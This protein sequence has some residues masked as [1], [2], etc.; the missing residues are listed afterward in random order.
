M[1]K[2][3]A[4]TAPEL[5]RLR[6]PLSPAATPPLLPGVALPVMHMTQQPNTACTYSVGEVPKPLLLPLNPFLPIKEQLMRL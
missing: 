3:A 1:L 5:P 4:A 6:L 2:A